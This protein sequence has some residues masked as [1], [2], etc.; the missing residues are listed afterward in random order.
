[1][2]DGRRHPRRRSKAQR[3]HGCASGARRLQLPRHEPRPLL[4][5]CPLLRR[6]SWARTVG[7]NLMQPRLNFKNGSVPG[8]S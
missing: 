4:Q 2:L 1:M 6:K 5:Q 7:R 8:A 3:N